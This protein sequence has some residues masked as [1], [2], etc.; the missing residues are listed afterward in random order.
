MK[1]PYQSNQRQVMP[2]G[3]SAENIALQSTPGLNPFLDTVV[4]ISGEKFEESRALDI[5]KQQLDILKDLNKFNNDTEASLKTIDD[6]IKY[7]QEWNNALKNKIE[8]LRENHNPEVIDGMLGDL[9]NIE[10]KITNTIFANAQTKQNSILVNDLNNYIASDLENENTNLEDTLVDIVLTETEIDNLTGRGVH[11]IQVAE[12]LKVEYKKDKIKNLSNNFKAE[13]RDTIINKSH[14]RD[15]AAALIPRFVERY[16]KIQETANKELG[17]NTISK[18]AVS[19]FS[20]SLYL[21]LIDKE[22]TSA[23]RY[24][25]PED[26]ENLDL[27]NKL[28]PKA[29]EKLNKD[30]AGWIDAAE[31]QEVENIAPIIL[32]SFDDPNDFLTPNG[33][34]DVKEIKKRVLEVT[35]GV[36]FDDP[37]GEKQKLWNKLSGKQQSDLKGLALTRLNKTL[38]FLDNQQK[39]EDENGQRNNDAVAKGL[40]EKLSNGTLNIADVEGAEFSNDNYG[41]NL[42]SEFLVLAENLQTNKIRTSSNFNAMKTIKERIVAPNNKI[43]SVN[44]PFTLGNEEI[45]KP[46]SILQRLALDKGDPRALSQND[47]EHLKTLLSLRTDQISIDNNNAYTKLFNSLEGM[48]YDSTNKKDTFGPQRLLQFQMDLLKKFQEGLDNGI[49]ASELINQ[50]SEHYVPRKLDMNDYIRTSKEIQDDFMNRRKKEGPSDWNTIISPELSQETTRTDITPDMIRP[51]GTI[52]S[53]Q[54]WLGPIADRQGNTMTELSVNYSD[55]LDAKLI[56]LLVPT[57]TEDEIETLQR[58]KF[59]DDG[60]IPEGAIPKSIEKKAIEHAIKRVEQ[61]YS[62]FYESYTDY[63]MRVPKKPSGKNWDEH[64]A[65]PEYQQWLNSRPPEAVQN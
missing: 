2:T 1:I 49:P 20:D 56:P 41:Q 60:K 32:N 40:Y 17:I 29:A 5:Q 8:S 7:S 46:L 52:K 61:G 45:D 14:N 10:M 18:E 30:L 51:D 57:L 36:F 34:R 12:K 44:T 31:K 55:V 42:K 48:V 6:P 16:K 15:E 58:I 33:N 19:D 24:G 27:I 64:K 47:F 3:G 53:A 39:A 54:G 50:K 26:I 13:S 65:S 37:D 38:S 59:T 43:F 25:N 28:S 9:T 11:D 62:P 21:S 4:K 22:V 63:M 35:R 23:I